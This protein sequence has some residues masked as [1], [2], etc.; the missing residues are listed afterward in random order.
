MGYD[1]G[2]QLTVETNA[3]SG[4]KGSVLII[5]NESRLWSTLIVVC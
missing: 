5:D 3:L 2:G 4:V 1:W